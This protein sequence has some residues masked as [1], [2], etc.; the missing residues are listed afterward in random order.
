MVSP[1]KEVPID[2]QTDDKG[3]EYA[4]EWCYKQK[5]ESSQYADG[6]NLG[7]YSGDQRM[8][9]NDI[10]DVLADHWYEAN[11]HIVDLPGL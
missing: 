8:H 2:K 4:Q 7:R 3:W 9:C 11:H 10:A 6:I 5:W 1:G